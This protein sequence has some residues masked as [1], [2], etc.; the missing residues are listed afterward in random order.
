MNH[1]CNEIGG[2]TVEFRSFL[3]VLRCRNHRYAVYCNRSSKPCDAIAQSVR[4]NFSNE[5]ASSLG[6]LEG[7]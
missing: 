3:M 4:F 1:A 5:Y 2:N 7:V 6:D